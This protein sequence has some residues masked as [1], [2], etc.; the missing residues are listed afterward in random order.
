MYKITITKEENYVDTEKVYYSKEE[1]SN[2]G[3]GPKENGGYV[4][5]EFK[6]TREKMILQQNVEELDLSEVIKAINKL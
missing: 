2:M 5:R 6:K 4:N 1:L 3:M